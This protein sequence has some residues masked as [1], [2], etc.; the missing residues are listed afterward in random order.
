MSKSQSDVPEPFADFFLDPMTQR[1]SE[2][3]IDL[4]DG[5]KRATTAAFMLGAYRLLE[6]FRNHP[7]LESIGLTIVTSVKHKAD[8]LFPNTAELLISHHNKLVTT[9]DDCGLE[10]Q[11][12]QQEFVWRYIPFQSINRGHYTLTRDDPQV[13]RYLA[14]ELSDRAGREHAVHEVAFAMSSSFGLLKIIHSNSA[15]D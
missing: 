3:A 1:S 10:S 4:E 6:L 11:D 5:A 13:A 15:L 12:A 2:Y 7:K 9:G 8:G 14:A